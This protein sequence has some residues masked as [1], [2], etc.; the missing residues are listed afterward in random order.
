MR[1]KNMKELVLRARAHA[2]ADRIQ[3]ETYGLGTVNGKAEFK[4]CWIGCLSTPHRKRDLFPYL[5]AARERGVEKATAAAFPI[6]E[7]D[8]ISY[9]LD[10]DE[11]RR[12]IRE[13]FG[14]N[15]GLLTVA[16]SLFESLS[17]DAARSFLVDFCVLL[18]RL[19]GAN[20]AEQATRN[21]FST[22]L[23]RAGVN[24]LVREMVTDKD[25]SFVRFHHTVA[26]YV[27]DEVFAWLESKVPA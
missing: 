10:N 17:E 4:G 9:G 2:R 1:L 18:E 8:L 26:L 5:R 11:Q 27:R 3:Q 13:E 19:E 22:I 20:F 21:K 15:N 16:E 25:R 12:L 23:K 7:G 24:S 6:P 14:I